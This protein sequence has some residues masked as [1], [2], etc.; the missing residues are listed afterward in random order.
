MTEI[1]PGLLDV[2][3]DHHGPSGAEQGRFDQKIVV[4]TIRTGLLKNA[5]IEP[6]RHCCKSFARAEA[7]LSYKM[8]LGRDMTS[9]RR[10]LKSLDRRAGR[11]FTGGQYFRE[12]F[13]GQAGHHE[14]GHIRQ[15][16]E[17]NAGKV[18]VE[19]LGY[20]DGIIKSGIMRLVALD[21]EEDVPDHGG[22]L[23]AARAECRN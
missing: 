4:C 16:A 17:S 5:E 3:H 14:G 18:S 22:S 21:L 9:L 1:Q 19:C 11:L 12:R 13:R 2:G 7:T 8:V 15:V 20:C 10:R 6:S 23:A